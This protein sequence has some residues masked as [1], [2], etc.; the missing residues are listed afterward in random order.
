MKRRRVSHLFIISI[1]FLIVI[2]ITGNPRDVQANPAGSNPQFGLAFITAADNIASPE[3]L[4]GA[5]TAGASWDR[6]PLYWHWVA[7]QGYVGSFF[8][9]D[10]V[11]KQNVQRNL[12][13]IAILLG[14]PDM[15]ASAGSLDVAPP[16]VEAKSVLLS[17]DVQ[18]Q[19]YDVSF[20]ASPPLG[21]YQPIFAD[22]T[23]TGVD[24]TAINQANSWASFVAESVER[25]RPGGALARS[26]GW[27]GSQGVRH[28]EIWNEPDL[29]QFWNGS[30][31]E[32]YRLMQVA[33]TT[34]KSIDP[35]ATVLI[36]GL[37][38][39]EDPAFFPEYLALG[40]ANGSQYYFDVVSYHYYWSIY[41]GEHWFVEVKRLLNQH[42]LGQTPIWITESGVPV[43]DD[44]PATQYNVPPNSPWRATMS[45]QAAYIIQKSATA[46]YHGVDLYTHFM[47]HDDCGNAPADAFGLRQ[48]FSPHACNPAGGGYRPGYSAYRL[49]AT[50][51][52]NLQPLER[53]KTSTYDHLVFYRPHDQQ[54]LHVIW[55]TGGNGVYA[56]IPTANSQ[57][58]LFWVESAGGNARS[59]NLVRSQ[60]IYPVNGSYTVFLNGATN[61]NSNIPNDPTYYIGGQ[62][63]ILVEANVSPQPQVTPTPTFTPTPGPPNYTHSV[64]LPMILRQRHQTMIV[65][66][67]TP[68]VPPQPGETVSVS[69]Q[70]LNS[71]GFA[72]SQ[73]VVEVDRLDSSRAAEFVTDAQGRWRGTLPPGTYNFRSRAANTNAW[74]QARRL[75]IAAAT[76]DILLNTAPGGNQIAGG[77]FES[78][79]VWQYWQITNG[80]ATLSS[81]AFDGNHALRL[82]DQPGLPITCQQ[83]GQPGEIWTAKQAVTIPGSGNPRLSFINRIDTTQ[84]A[85]DYAWLEV[86]LVDQGQAHYLVNWGERWEN[87]AW[88]LSTLDVSPWAGK[89]VDL[90]FQVVNCSAHTFVTSLDRIALGT[91]A[92]SALP[93]ATPNPNIDFQV[94]SR[95]LTACENMGKHHLF[96]YVEDAQGRGI[97]EMQVKVDWGEDHAI[98]TTGDKAEHAGLVDFAMY[99][100]NYTVELV[101]ARAPKAGPFTTDIPVDEICPDNGQYGNTW[102]HY[103]YEIVY[104]QQ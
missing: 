102:F 77:D 26:Q 60:T 44:F 54:R 34:I 66:T 87:R 70:V 64:Y 56:N 12:T 40:A 42:G 49:A 9:Y 74:P 68:T 94:Q 53:H 41:G 100:G 25:Y 39:F 83:N 8:N 48:N 32:Y 3:R 11:V 2:I 14:T 90:L 103:S 59:D 23:D 82:G 78:T 16:R 89:T 71:A 29:D 67:A 21:L 28:W 95:Q 92:E 7:G 22:G 58:R 50:E 17:G 101:G 33:Y 15:R 24:S 63:F 47:L 35:Q 57:G 79:H 31:A 62:P 65:P 55:A 104:T 38:F 84:Q 97:P 10:E 19:G 81:E 80:A 51:F 1:A 52:R 61:R 45:E 27:G 93:T 43:W 75:N 4:D 6:W 5:L 76:S 69:G 85:F 99:P 36:G 20:A 98:L 72:L 18:A 37:S 96:I 46:F 88:A 91:V 30:V 73:A 86:V 13:P